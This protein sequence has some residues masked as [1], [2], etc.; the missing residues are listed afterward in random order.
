MKVQV[1]KIS[2]KRE[3][4]LYFR[5]NKFGPSILLAQY[6]VKSYLAN[7]AIAEISARG[8]FSSVVK[9]WLRNNNPLYSISSS[10]SERLYLYLV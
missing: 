2:A 5:V 7:L 4:F 6:P 1:A 3:N 10:Y 9:F 8:H